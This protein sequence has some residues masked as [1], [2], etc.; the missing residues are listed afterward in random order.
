MLYPIYRPVILDIIIEEM[1]EFPYTDVLVVGENI[2]RNQNIIL[3][4]S[5]NWIS[6]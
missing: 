5:Y 3:E 4:R 6:L 1:P 2:S